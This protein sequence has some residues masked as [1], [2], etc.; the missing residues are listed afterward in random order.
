MDLR[1]SVP[2]FGALL[3]LAGT[4]AHGWAQTDV[5]ELGRALGGA[6]PPPQ[7]YEMLRRDPTAFQFSQ[8]NGWIVR[9]K[10]VA[11]RRNALRASL[12]HRLA[13]EPAVAFSPAVGFNDDGI[14]RGVLNVPVFLILFANTDSASLVANVPRT[15]LQERL[16]GTDAAPPYSVHT[17]YREISNDSVLVNG[18]VL[19]W[20]RV[21]QADTYYEAGCNGLCAP[22]RIA[23]MVQDLVRAHDDTVDFGL[24]DND[25]PDGIPN[26]GDDDGYVDAIV[27]MHPEVDGACKNVNP[28]SVDNIWA[29]R[30]V[31]S[32][33]TADTSLATGTPIRLRDY[34]IQ[35]GQGGD[36]GC[37]DNQPQAMG[38][39][40]H[41]TGHVFGLPD[42]YDT[43]S[44]GG[45]QGIGHWGLMGSGNWRYA[46]SPAHME[47]WSRA[48]LGWVQEVVIANDTVL[49]IGPIETSDTAYVVPI[50]GSSEYFLLE[51]R[52]PI[53]SDAQ[54]HGPGLLIWHVDSALVA[55]RWLGNW[56]NSAFPYGLALEE[57]DGRTDLQATSG[58]NR[59]EASD[60]FPGT[61]GNRSFGMGTTPASD[62]NDGTPSYIAIDSIRGGAAPGTV[63]FQ[64][65]IN[66]LVVMASD[67]AAVVRVDGADHHVFRE[68]VGPG[69]QHLLDID[70]V[71]T[72][73]GGRRRYTWLSW[74]N[75]Q[76]RTH[77]ATVMPGDTIVANV[78]SEFLLEAAVQG[79]GG[80]VSAAP[81]V[82]LGG[83]FIA[84]D[85]L[86]TLVAQVSQSGYVFEGWS[87]DTVSL[88]DTLRIVMAHPFAV[89]ATF[90]APLVI[91]N[92]DPDTAVMGANYRYQLAATG[93]V[94]AQDWTIAAG[95]LPR[96]VTFSRAGEFTG[97]PEVTGQFPIAVRLTSGTQSVTKDYQFEVVAPLLAASNVV[98][99]VTG[100]GSH[101]S[102]EE[103]VYLDL[104]G[105]KNNV[106]DVG[107]FLAWVSATGATMTP[108]AM[109]AVMRAR[110]EDRP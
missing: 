96:G 62:R 90:A 11:A 88:A 5:E 93:G 74:S 49:E 22:S 76:A 106:L 47:A 50:K 2:V 29:H 79:S 44:S 3:L 97:R 73:D 42:L 78:E 83:T 40:A 21:S 86:V 61:T 59:G 68:H 87:G 36:G 107:D 53:G 16:Y 6:K 101:L 80:A 75:G 8:A 39:V 25:G 84:K 89:T 105:N 55:A 12:A 66:P 35:G 20:A 18:T 103:I 13:S 58:G 15:S 63:H 54:M 77:T 67:T 98:A 37:T 45:G 30:W 26:S 64:V 94:T 4:A 19:D 9:G 92:A 81:S 69:E 33:T 104:L 108:E 23:E 82:D 17:Y 24:F 7:Y 56:V 48:Q 1:R 41:E 51:N 60:P 38:V 71:Q 10:A 65:G 43:R 72:I 109:L 34:I 31:T 57:A 27:L 102:A 85:S 70:S 95:A 91:A 110:E 99:H 46:Y 28:A 100:N 32:A 14:M 52:Q